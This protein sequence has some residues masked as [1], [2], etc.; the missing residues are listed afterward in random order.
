[1]SLFN[2][3]KGQFSAFE[4]KREKILYCGFGNLLYISTQRNN[5]LTFI[6]VLENLLDVSIHWNAYDCFK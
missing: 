4:E 5:A 1:M 6:V 2:M 3:M